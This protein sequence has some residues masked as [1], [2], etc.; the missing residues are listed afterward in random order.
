MAGWLLQS[1]RRGNTVSGG[2]VTQ[3]ISRTIDYL[4]SVPGPLV[5]WDP[6]ADGA[7]RE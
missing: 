5:E 1:C 4:A 6:E 2:F 7:W 3:N